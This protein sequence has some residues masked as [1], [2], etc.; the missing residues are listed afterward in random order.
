M[1][2]TFAVAVLV[3]AAAG[4]SSVPADEV[5]DIKEADASMVTQCEFLGDV[6]SIAMWE[7]KP[8]QGLARVKNG[9]KMNAKKLGATHVI[10][11]PPTTRPLVQ[12]GKAYRC[13]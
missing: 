6:E 13:P 9:V 11:N 12:T 5:S 8:T 4:C 7:M 1:K 2:R 3:L 10:L